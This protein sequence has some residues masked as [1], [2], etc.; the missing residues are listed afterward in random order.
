MGEFLISTK[1]GRMRVRFG[2]FDSPLYNHIEVFKINLFENES[3]EKSW[4]EEGKF[5]Q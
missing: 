4:K 1:N 2:Y 3:C 5:K